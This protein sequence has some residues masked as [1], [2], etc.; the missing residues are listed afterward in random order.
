MLKSF[1]KQSIVYLF[2]K[3]LLFLLQIYVFIVITRSVNIVHGAR[4]YSINDEVTSCSGWLATII[5]NFCNNTYKIVK[6]DTS[7]M[8]GIYLDLSILLYN[9]DYNK[10]YFSV[11]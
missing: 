6:R 1:E 10:P 7:L 5:F 8:I 2:N 11:Q 4:T 9:F 3:F